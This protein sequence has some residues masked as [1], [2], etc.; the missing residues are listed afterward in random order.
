MQDDGDPHYIPQPARTTLLALMV[1]CAE[2][3][4]MED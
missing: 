4:N 2:L 3:L 1:I